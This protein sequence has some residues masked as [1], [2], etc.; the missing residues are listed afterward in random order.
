MSSMAFALQIPGLLQLAQL[1]C[2]LHVLSM[3]S[4]LTSAP[5]CP[6]CTRSASITRAALNPSCIQNP[7]HLLELLKRFPGAGRRVRTGLCRTT[8]HLIIHCN[9]STQLDIILTRCC[10]QA[11][12]RLAQLAVSHT[13][14][15]VVQACVKFGTPEERALVLAE[16]RPS[17]LD[18]AKSSYAHFTVTK[19]IALAPKADVP[20]A[21]SIY[22]HDHT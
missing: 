4:C 14:S 5:T 20:G 22:I 1:S 15:R 19:L 18:L 11:K 2:K 8:M 12:G 6:H 17:L 3:Q 7:S 16:L 21:P 10:P 9:K 13:G